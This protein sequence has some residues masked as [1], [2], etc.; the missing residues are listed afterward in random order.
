MAMVIIAVVIIMAV[1]RVVVAVIRAAVVIAPRKGSGKNPEK[2][3]PRREKG[4][5]L[6]FLI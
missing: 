3:S 1:A 5:P 6:G 2:F 4:F